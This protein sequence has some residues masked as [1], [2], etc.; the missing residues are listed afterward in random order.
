MDPSFMNS[1]AE[2]GNVLHHDWRK[3]IRCL[4][5]LICVPTIASGVPKDRFCDGATERT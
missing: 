5:S 1:S 2:F 4:W 3:G